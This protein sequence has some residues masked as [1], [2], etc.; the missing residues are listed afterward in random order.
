MSSRITVIRNGK[1]FGPYSPQQVADYLRQNKLLLN[2]LACLDNDP[3][4]YTVQSILAKL[5]IRVNPEPP[6]ASI[7]KIGVDFLFPWASIS[8]MGWRKDFRFW[9]LALAGLLP[10]AFSVFAT[11]SLVYVGLAVYASILWGLFFF[12]QFKTDQVQ[13]KTCIQTMGISCLFIF[14]LLLLNTLTP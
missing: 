1:S 10:L 13:V 2:D 11:G 5:G 3:Q 12:S 6:M 9:V 7:K 14:A 4:T 8:N